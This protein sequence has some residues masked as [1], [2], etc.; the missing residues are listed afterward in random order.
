MSITI[1]ITIPDQLEKELQNEADATGISRSRFIGNLLL[2]WQEDINSIFV[3]KPN[4]CDHRTDNGFCNFFNQICQA[5]Q[6]DANAC[7]GYYK[8]D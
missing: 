6:S 1:S 5:S 7:A 8:K 2:K 3:N 4:N